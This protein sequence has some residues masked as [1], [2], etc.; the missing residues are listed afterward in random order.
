MTNG[1]FEYAIAFDMQTQTLLKTLD[2][3]ER[4]EKHVNIANNNANKLRE[5]LNSVGVRGKIAFDGIAGSLQSVVGWISM[6]DI[7]RR[8]LSLGSDA[9][10]TGV[11]FR[12]MLQ[13]VKVANNLLA[14]LNTFANVTPFTNKEVIDA[15]RLLV[16]YGM[17]AKSIIPTL[18][19]VGNVASGLNIPLKELTSIYGKL[20]I[21][22]IVHTDDINMLSERGVPVIRELGRMLH[23]SS[24]K[25]L[26]MAEDGKISSA[27]MIQ[28]LGNMAGK[29]GQFA[30]MMAAQGE[31]VG[32]KW[33][34]FMGTMEML[35]ITIG[36]KLMP[37]ALN[38]LNNYLI[39]GATWLSEHSDLVISIV[40]NFL[41]LSGVVKVFSLAKAFGS[42][43]DFVGMFEQ[44]KWVIDGL[45][46]GRIYMKMV[47]P[48]QAV[49][50]LFRQLS[51]GI[52]S[53]FAANPV[54]WVIVGLV[55][56]GAAIFVLWNKFAW[57]RGMV[58]G[59]WEVVSGLSE[60]LYAGLVQPVWNG[61][62][63]IVGF[64]NDLK[65]KFWDFVVGYVVPLFEKLGTAL[66]GI[67]DALMPAW[68][69][70]FNLPKD[71]YGLGYAK[72]E[73]SF[74]DDQLK[75]IAPKDAIS[76]IFGSSGKTPSGSIGGEDDKLKKGVEAITG[77]GT[78]NTNIVIHKMGENITIQTTN[79][80][81]GAE[82]VQAIL[83]RMLLQIVNSANQTQ[84]N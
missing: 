3:L 12:V 27:M 63:K 69:K 39:P 10:Q 75:G 49:Q 40:S 8:V 16:G 52:V 29:G 45:N 24:G 17:S 37:T 70:L 32:G 38:L 46:F 23:V 35:G 62:V 15:G 13:D 14:D 41:A 26:K 42:V 33:S 20:T 54:F 11:A 21:K 36:T 44:V 48:V 51:M 64:L 66:G 82:E 25:V 7:G 34:T 55:A 47:G 31:T 53:A 67:F 73:K 19:T 71:L 1:G 65:T 43:K 84:A 4:L 22:P 60:R 56:L 81:Q 2:T 79:L 50:V 5:S 78:R 58:M 59:V 30:G 77:G 74:Y 76:S 18:T 9:E 6:I 83:S 80:Q 28:A 68:T 61:L 57:F 72:G